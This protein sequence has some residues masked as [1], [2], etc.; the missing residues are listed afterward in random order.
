MHSV[1]PAILAPPKTP[2]EL[3][4]VLRESLN[5]LMTDSDFRQQWGKQFGAVY[6]WNPTE[7]SI[8]ALKNYRNVKPEYK[9]VL[10]EMRAIGD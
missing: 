2:P 5:A 8:A 4:K 1:S 10:A 9:E 6:Y 7:A 3:F